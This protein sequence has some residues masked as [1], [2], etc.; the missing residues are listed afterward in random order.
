MAENKKVYFGFMGVTLFA[1]L[2]VLIADEIDLP[3]P[4]DE[5]GDIVSLFRL[6]GC[7]IGRRGRVIDNDFYVKL[8]AYDFEREMSKVI[9]IGGE[10]IDL[11]Y[12]ENICSTKPLVRVRYIARRTVSAPRKVYVAKEVEII[13][14]QGGRLHDLKS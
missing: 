11:K 13:G 12:Y 4:E 14:G 7:E 6:D 1:V 10:V 8:Y 5:R 3:V 9:L 2:L